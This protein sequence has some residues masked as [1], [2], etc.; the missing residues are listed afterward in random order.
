MG[1][2]VFTKYAEPVDWL[3]NQIAPPRNFNI[4]SFSSL[5]R[6]AGRRFD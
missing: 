1:R 3:E 4:F 6:A 2:V 5:D